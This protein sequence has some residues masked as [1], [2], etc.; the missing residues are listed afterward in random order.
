[1]ECSFLVGKSDSIW[2]RDMWCSKTCGWLVGDEARNVALGLTMKDVICQAKEFR[3]HL[4]TYE[5]SHVGFYT[6]GSFMFVCLFW[7]DLSGSSS[8]EVL[9]EKRLELGCTVR[10]ISAAQACDDEV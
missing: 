7:E 2:P 1:M 5:R 8:R 4:G 9:E 10:A 6:R 3:F